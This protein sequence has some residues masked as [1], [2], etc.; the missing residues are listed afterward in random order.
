MLTYIFCIIWATIFTFFAER[1][2][3]HV[4]IKSN[5]LHNQSILSFLHRIFN[6]KRYNS[7]KEKKNHKNTQKDVIHNKTNKS[8]LAKKVNKNNVTNIHVMDKSEGKVEVIMPQVKKDKYVDDESMLTPRDRKIVGN[9]FFRPRTSLDNK[10]LS[11][12]KKV[13]QANIINRD[14]IISDLK[15]NTS[16]KYETIR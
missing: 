9:D 13:V 1:Q 8:L 10:Q 11:R 3:R 6:S 7:E 15:K 12:G 2:F 4:P 5:K 16:K 14:Y